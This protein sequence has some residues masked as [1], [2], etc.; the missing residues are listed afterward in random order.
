MAANNNKIFSRGGINKAKKQLSGLRSM[1]AEHEKAKQEPEWSVIEDR[2]WQSQHCTAYTCKAM[3]G[4]ILTHDLLSP[5]SL[6]AVWRL[7]HCKKCGFMYH[8][9]LAASPSLAEYYIK[10]GGDLKF[11]I[12]RSPNS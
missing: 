7:I 9:R 10:F 8:P 3:Y 1:L 6:A 5:M 4:Y 11:F 2:A 12:A